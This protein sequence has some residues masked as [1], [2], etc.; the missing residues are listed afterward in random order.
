[1]VA[2]V[3]EILET[4]GF[5]LLIIILWHLWAA[6]CAPPSPPPKPIPADSQCNH[7]L[8]AMPLLLTI[9]AL[10]GRPSVP[11]PFS[12]HHALQAF[13]LPC[14]V[15]EACVPVTLPGSYLEHSRHPSRWVCSWRKGRG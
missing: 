4:A 7:R 15:D 8:R 11:A 12:F 2:Q 10:A 5:A 1:M 13:G 3:F 6:L 9:V 14:Q